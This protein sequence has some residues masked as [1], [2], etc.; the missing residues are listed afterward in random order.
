MDQNN[1]QKC[2]CAFVQYS[3]SFADLADLQANFAFSAVCS[4]LT[5]TRKSYLHCDSSSLTTAVFQKKR[6]GKNIQRRSLER[7]RQMVNCFLHRL[8]AVAVAYLFLGRSNCQFVRELSLVVTPTVCVSE[9]IRNNVGQ[10]STH[11]VAFLLTH[12]VHSELAHTTA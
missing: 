10:N 6:R 11:N 12:L 7:G 1:K 8:V 5:R 2:I 4:F 3:R 9:K